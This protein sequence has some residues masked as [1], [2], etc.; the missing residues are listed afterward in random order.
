M[1][2]AYTPQPV[3]TS[4]VDL[5][6]ELDGLIERLA[7]SNHDH[8]ALRRL[9]E[10]WTYGPERDDEAMQHPDLRAYADLPESEREY[11]RI[12]VVETLK[13]VVALGYRIVPP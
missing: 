5:P 10:G 7:A 11:D 9:A 3:E 1:T 8:W 2:D 12:T 13:A 6:R 4:D